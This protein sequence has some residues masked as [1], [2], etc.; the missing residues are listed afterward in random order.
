M[1]PDK[2]TN[3]MKPPSDDLRSTI[4]CAIVGSLN[5]VII[6]LLIPTNFLPSQE[7]YFPVMAIFLI[8]G[9]IMGMFFG[10]VIRTVI[11]LIRRWRG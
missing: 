2:G 11:G 6:S 7:S 8:V 1:T 3:P 10:I 9:A 5:G 4:N